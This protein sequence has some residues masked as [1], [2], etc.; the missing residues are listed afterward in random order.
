[1]QNFFHSIYVHTDQFLIF[2]YRLTHIPILDFLIGTFNLACLCVIIGEL[3]VS[4]ALKF[5]KPYVDQ[6]TTEM[7]EKERLSMMAYQAGDKESYKALNKEATDV[8]GKSF[9][10]MVAHSAAILWPLPFAMGW[11]GSRFAEVDFPVAAPL[12]FLFANGVGYMFTFIPMY[13]LSRILFKYMRPHLP[14]FKGVQKML[15]AADKAG[16]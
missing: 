6:M 12:S 4:L 8:W 2:F 5:N 1:M 10:T 3:S 11:L 15:D 7:R 14:Y 13:I 9:F 16:R